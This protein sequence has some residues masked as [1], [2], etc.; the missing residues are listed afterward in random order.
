MAHDNTEDRPPTP[1]ELRRTMVYLRAKFLAD[2]RRL[3]PEDVAS[4]LGVSYPKVQNM[5]KLGQLSFQKV[6]GRLTISRHALDRDLA[7][8]Y[9]S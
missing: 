5:I 9:A 3:S 1:G 2:E 4:I 7:E 6:G 8:L